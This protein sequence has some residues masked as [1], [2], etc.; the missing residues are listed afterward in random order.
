M[1]EYFKLTQPGL[2]LP[3]SLAPLIITALIVSV[4]FLLGLLAFCLCRQNQARKRD[5]SRDN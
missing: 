2:E 3:L 4:I 1:L 5:S